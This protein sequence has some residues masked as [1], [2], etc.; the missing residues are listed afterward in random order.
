MASTQDDAAAKTFAPPTGKV[1]IYIVRA[2]AIIAGPIAYDVAID[3]KA[4]GAIAPGTF[5][6]LTVEPGRHVIRA[7]SKENTDQVKIDAEADKNY[8]LEVS[9]VLGFSTYRAS[10]KQIEED[11]GKELVKQEKRAESMID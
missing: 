10:I 6:L 1:N 11:K 7:S 2:S 8:F 3:G 5:Y 9:P 4:V